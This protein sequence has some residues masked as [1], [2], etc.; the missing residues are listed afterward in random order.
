MRTYFEHKTLVQSAMNAYNASH[1]TTIESTT[2]AALKTI[3]GLFPIGMLCDSFDVTAGDDAW[4]P[5]NLAG[6][7]AVF[8][9]EKRRV[10]ERGKAASNEDEELYRFYTEMVY[11]AS[12]NDDL[13]FAS[14]GSISA[15]ESD[16]TC[17]DLFAM[18][19]AGTDIVGMTLRI[20][21]ATHGEYYYT[22]DSINED[23]TIH[24]S[25]SHPY[26][27]TDSVV[28]ILRETS[29]RIRFVDTLEQAI[30]TGTFTVHYW[31]FPNPLSQNTDIIPLEYPDLLELITI[32]RIPET[33]N[34]R[35]VSKTEIDDAFAL[36]KKRE[37][38]QSFPSKPRGQ[39][40]SPIIAQRSVNGYKSRGR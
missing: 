34:R 11:S 9:S 13:P 6:I 25:G 27:E 19:E 22:I 18:S 14:T 2:N 37:P 12:S 20:V 26:A 28:T 36:A 7:I 40:G 3:C 1:S 33:K 31:K 35:P 5:D 15:G 8:D 24:L 16:L 32:R 21:N 39:Q 10:W 29:K 30:E 23:E 38:D 17:S 4:L